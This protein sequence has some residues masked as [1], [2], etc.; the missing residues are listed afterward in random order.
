MNIAIIPARKG[1]K[2]IK[3]KN[4]KFFFNKP[5]IAW[6]LLSLKK[7]KLFDKIIVTS[8][9]TKILKISKRFG[10]DIIIKRSKLL[11]NDH[12]PTYP[13]ILD[14]I[15]KIKDIFLIKNICC[16]YPCNP[17]LEIM[18]IHKSF[19]LLKKNKNSYIFPVARYSHPIQ[20]ALKLEKG[21]NLSYIFR[22]YVNTRTQ[23]LSPSFYD[24]G[25]F[26]LATKNTWLN[27]KNKNKKA[28]EIP[29]WRVHDIDNLSDWKRARMLFK[30]E[31]LKKKI[32]SD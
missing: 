8:D 32:A 15:K 2:R 23:D 26:Y 9:S 24:A 25:Q 30:Y 29:S 28:I 17:F 20:R 10:A 1:S 14:A 13:V 19:S 21:L 16:V 11:S 7:S 12:T 27:N 5:M 31:I 22:K 18:D 3:N 6:T 4:I